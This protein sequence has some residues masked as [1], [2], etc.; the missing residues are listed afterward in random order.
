MEDKVLQDLKN[1]FSAL[2]TL[3]HDYREQDRLIDEEAC[4]HKESI[5]ELCEENAEL[6]RKLLEFEKQAN[7][8]LPSTFEGNNMEIVH[9]WIN[10]KEIY[11]ISTY[12]TTK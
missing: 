7:H 3:T 1:L 9:E 12:P 2:Q 5:R 11:R 6:K 10:D 8:I 4:K